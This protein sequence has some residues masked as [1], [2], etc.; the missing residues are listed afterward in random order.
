MSFNG[1]DLAVAVVALLSIALG[2][3]RG[4]LYELF[5]LG[6]WVVAFVVARLFASDVAGQLPMKG[7]SPEL[8]MVVAFVGLFIATAFAAGLLSWLVRKLV[9][10]S[11]L[12]PVDRSLGMV[13]G[14]ARATLI[15]VIV[16]LVAGATPL[17]KQDVWVRSASGPWLLKAADYGKRWLPEEL[18]KVLD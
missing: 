18:E 10:V 5:S 15:L 17:A 11:G 9:S 16:G 2:A 1:L 14:M 6:G 8:R 12:R 3:W 7:A 4:F 13:F